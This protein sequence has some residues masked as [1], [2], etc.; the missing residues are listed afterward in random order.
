MSKFADTVVYGKIYTSNAN[1]DYACAFAVKDGKYLYVGSEDGVS[2]YIQDG[3]TKIVD[4][5]DKGIVMAG[6]PEG[7]GH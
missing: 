7:H 1:Q 6:A 4:Y 3:S 5:R 2:Q